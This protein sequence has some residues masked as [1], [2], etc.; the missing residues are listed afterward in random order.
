MRRLVRVIPTSDPILDSLDHV[1]AKAGYKI[2]SY[3]EKGEFP[4]GCVAARISGPGMPPNGLPFCVPDKG[5]DIWARR[6]LL[7]MSE[8][9]TRGM[10][11]GSK[12]R[13]S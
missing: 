3:D 13:P 8:A 4:E 10:F 9:Y 1:A 6:I 11:D 2:V 12:T 5:R 7:V